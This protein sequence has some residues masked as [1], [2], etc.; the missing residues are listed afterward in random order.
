MEFCAIHDCP[1]GGICQNL[2]DGYECLSSATFNGVNNTI[3]YASVGIDPA[4]VSASASGMHN[5]SFSFRTK[6]GGTVLSVDNAAAAGIRAIRLDIVKQGVVVRW[7]DASGSSENLVAVPEALDGQWH[8]IQLNISSIIDN[9][10]LSQMVAGG[11]VTLGGS[12]ESSIVKRQAPEAADIPELTTISSDA[13]SGD[14][15]PPAILPP[16]QHFRGCL[17]EFRI[18]ELLLPFFEAD[19]LSSDPSPRKFQVTSGLRGVELG[20]RLCYDAECRNDAVCLD[21][22]VNYTCNCLA[23]YQGDQCQVNI[24]ECVDN[25]CDKGTCVDRVANYT[26]ACDLGWTSWLCDEEINECEANPCQNEATCTDLIGTY[27]C[28]CTEDYTGN[29]CEKLKV[30]TCAN[31]PC[32]QGDCSDLYDP[33]TQLANNFTCLCPFGYQGLTCDQEIDYCVSLAPCQNGAI[34]TGFPFEPVTT[35]LPHYF[36][37]YSLSL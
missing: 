15:V 31:S 32:S 4:A 2:N 14:D 19:A 20:C 17:N 21:P 36:I 27:L 18:G 7:I 11:A 9:F 6:V 29:D 10:S 30:V 22:A 1:S 26:C 25:L 13:D 12:A 16:W 33:V 23:G 28:N 3:D 5:I 24:D 35:P 8:Q 37:H 34:C